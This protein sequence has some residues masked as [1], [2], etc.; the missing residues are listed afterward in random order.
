MFNVSKN[1][2]KNLD[3][4][5]DVCYMEFRLKKSTLGIFCLV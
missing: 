4:V 3:V 1:E 5:R 2:K